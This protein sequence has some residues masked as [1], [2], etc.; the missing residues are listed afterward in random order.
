MVGRRRDE[1]QRVNSNL[2]FPQ[3]VNKPNACREI[4]QPY[5][6]LVAIAYRD[7][8]G[9]LPQPSEWLRTAGSSLGLPHH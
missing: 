2:S 1:R 3:E 7:A 8:A 5:S 4:S 9:T 6:S